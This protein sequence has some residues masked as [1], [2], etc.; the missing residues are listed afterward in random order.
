MKKGIILIALAALFALPVKAQNNFNLN[1]D[2]FLGIG[3]GAGPTLFSST[4]FDE[5]IK[6]HLGLND[7]EEI[8]HYIQRLATELDKRQAG[9]KIC[10]RAILL[11]ILLIIL[12]CTPKKMLLAQTSTK[13]N[14]AVLGVVNEMERHP[15]RHYSLDNLAR[16]ASMC[17]S[18][19]TKK[20]RDMTGLSPTEYL[21]SLRIE[22]AEQ[23][24]LDTEKTVY[25]IADECGFYDINYFIKLF[26]RHRHTT[27][28]RFRKKQ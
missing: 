19:F 18:G 12:R 7:R 25:D 8:N 15:E 3:F 21:T 17:I 13:S 1:I 11:E 26:R 28:A 27:P 5:R 24:L 23:L 10:A 16:S 9:Y 2:E 20:F 6:V 14:H 22:K 4:A